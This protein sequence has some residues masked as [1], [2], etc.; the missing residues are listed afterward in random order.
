M[1]PGAVPWKHHPRWVQRLRPGWSKERLGPFQSQQKS[2]VED[3]ESVSTPTRIDQD[4]HQS[5][6]ISPAKP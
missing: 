1:V 4:T 3:P 6:N 2:N 5:H